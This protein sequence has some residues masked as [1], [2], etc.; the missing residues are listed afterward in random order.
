MAEDMFPPIVIGPPEQKEIASIARDINRPFFGQVLLNTDDTLIT[1][2]GGKGLKIYDELER[3]T[4]AYA[5]LHKRK[6]AVISRPWDIMPAS[7]SSED[8]AVAELVREHLKRLQLDRICTEL[9]DATLKGF[10]VGEIMWQVRGSEIAAADVIPR[11]QRR[12][13]FDLERALRL[14]TLEHMTEGEQLPGRKFIVH[15]VGGKDGSPYGLGLGHR[16]FWPV[17]FKRKDIGFWL[18]FAD[19]F[20]SPTSVGKYPP[21]AGL[22]DQQ[23]L[24]DALGAIAQDA[25]VIVPEGML[26]EL[27]E[28]TRSGSIDTY[29]KLA[30]Y[31]DEQ[32]SEAVLGETMTTTPA[33]TGLGSNQASVHERVGER[34]ARSDADLLS[35]T[36]NNSLVKWIVDYNAPGAPYPKLWRNFEEDEDLDKRAERDTKIKALGFETDEQYIEDTYGPG[37]KKSKVVTPPA[38][39]TIPPGGPDDPAA[40]AEGATAQRAANRAAQDELVQASEKLAGDWRA[41]MKQRLDDLHAILEQTGDLAMFRERMDELL[42]TEPPKNLVEAL[43]RAGFA[44]HVAGRATQS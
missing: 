44:A 2:G 19:K 15:S 8:Q 1:R 34:L 28:A 39:G 13:V 41:F 25:G 7:E 3:D 24:L 20:G 31:M 10:S 9:L 33:A 22:P 14:I 35:D 32:I 38:A 6:M 42:D 16:L 30:R 36:L 18:I 4:H 29:E 27:L 37:W 17:L 21:G 26:I 40:F 23:K 5:V 11:D 12:F 43:A